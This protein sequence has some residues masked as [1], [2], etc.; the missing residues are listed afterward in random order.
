MTVLYVISKYVTV[1][2]S[3][4][5]GLWEHLACGAF[6]IFVEDGRY[7]QPTEMCGHVEHELSPKKTSAFLFCFLPSLINALLAFVLGGAGFMGLFKLGVKFSE[8][9]F[10]LYIVLY[11]LGI[12]FFCNIFPLVED[13]MNNWSLI[14]DT[15][16]T[17]AEKERNEE[18]KRK[19][20]KN[21]AKEKAAQKAAKEKAKEV[22][23]T[24]P[25][26]I[27]SSAQGL[28]T[29]KSET[30]I[31]AKIL[32]FIPSAILYAGAFLEK[33]CVTFIISI[34][35]TVVSIILM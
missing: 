21:K 29:V 17:E 25:A 16:L 10:W 15:K 19:I 27:K 24:A 26:K 35:V 13:A 8:P 14:Y 30:G 18:I 12:S 28:E 11:Y 3:L 22:K 4:I 33:Y 6:K 2:G 32:L 5:K 9:V 20:A 23:G 1:F 31:V 34:A 7:L